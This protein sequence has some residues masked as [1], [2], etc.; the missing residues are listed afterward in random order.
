MA[1]CRSDP[2]QLSESWWNHSIWEVRSANRWDA[3]K[4][5]MPV[6]GTGPH[7][8]PSSLHPT[9]TARSTTSASKVEQIGPHSCLFRHIHLNSRQ[10]TTSSSSISTNFCRENASSISKRQKMLFKS[11]WNPKARIFMLQEWTKV[12]LTGKIALT[13]MDPILIN[14]DLFELSYNDLNSWSKTAIT[15]AN[16]SKTRE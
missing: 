6:A 1:S 7:R 16:K 12:F 10:P 4:T 8:G 9:L 14:K 5:A 13:V 11:L 2:L 3:P 15:F